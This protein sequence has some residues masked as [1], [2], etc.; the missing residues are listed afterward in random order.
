MIRY[1]ICNV[2]VKPMG[3]SGCTQP[4]VVG[5]QTG[6]LANIMTEESRAG[7]ARCPWSIRVEPGQT[8]ALTLINFGLPYMPGK[9]R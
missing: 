6:L 4:I 7:S 9:L 5:G 3:D 2:A 1:V 8:I